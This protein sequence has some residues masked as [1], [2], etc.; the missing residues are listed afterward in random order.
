LLDLEGGA[1]GEGIEGDV[2]RVV[3]EIR[4]PEGEDQVA[5]RGGARYVARLVRR[6]GGAADPGA[7]WRREGAYLITGGLGGVGL[8]IA[9][10]MVADGV[11]ELVLTGRRGMSERS[12]GD[13]GSRPSDAGRVVRA[14]RALEAQGA[15]VRVVQAD[16]SDRAQMAAALERLRVDGVRLSGVI[17]AAGVLGLAAVS[18]TDVAELERVLWPKVI[19]GWVLHELTR[20]MKIEQFILCSSAA[21]VWGARGLAAYAAANQFLDGLAQ[22]R[23]ALGLPALSVNWGP[24][25]GD[26]MAAGEAGAVLARVGVGTLPSAEASRVLAHLVA[27]DL[28]QVTVA[29]VDWRVFRPVYEAKGHR[30]LLDEIAVEDEDRGPGGTLEFVGR[31][32]QARADERRELMR[33]HVAATAAAVM[34]FEGEHRIDPRKGFFDLGMDSIMAVELVQ[35]LRATLG[36]AL[37]PAAVFDHPTVEALAAFLLHDLLAL[38]PPTAAAPAQP[39]EKDLDATLLEKIEKLTDTEAEALIRERLAAIREQN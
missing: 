6:E 39:L 8:A 36:V 5:F 30:A 35:R 3:D 12:D 27:S 31:L 29:A 18:E 14:I 16:V 21:A 19:G 23:R 37:S 25:R 10:Q 2:A 28:T 38:A 32:E 7:G 20:E 13:A 15:R 17:H 33:A 11:R 22:Y 26:G 9:R 1:G 34:R 4:D 24:W